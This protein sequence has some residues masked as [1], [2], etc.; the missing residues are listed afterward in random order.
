MD[1]KELL[2]LYVIAKMGALHNFVDLKSREFG[3]LL[4]MSQQTSSRRLITLEKKGWITREVSGKNQKVRLTPVGRDKLLSLYVDLKQMFGTLEGEL[5]VRGELVSGLG[6]GAY[7]MAQEQ[8]KQQ[9]Y[10]QLGYVPFPGTFNLALDEVNKEIITQMF[11]AR[12]NIHIEG[13]ANGNRTFGPVNCIS[14]S[15]DGVPCA[16]L[17]IERTHHEK[18]VIEIIAPENLRQK[19]SAADGD[20]FEVHVD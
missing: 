16:I 7:Y 18:Q 15:I 5:V 12:P 13:F 19:F 2:F 1:E 14:G 11:N 3:R 20:I 4:G 10:E 8:Y 9:F 17:R 6:E